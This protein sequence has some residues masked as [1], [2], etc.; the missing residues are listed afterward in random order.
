MVEILLRLLL[1]TETAATASI[2]TAALGQQSLLPWEKECGIFHRSTSTTAVRQQ[3][4]LHFDI[5][6]SNCC[7]RNSTASQQQST[8]R[9]DICGILLSSCA[10]HDNSKQ[11]VEQR[12]L[13]VVTGHGK[14]RS[15]IDAK[16]PSAI[17]RVC[18]EGL[19]S[20]GGAIPYEDIAENDGAFLIPASLAR[21]VSDSAKEWWKFVEH[22]QAWEQA[23]WHQHRYF[24]DP[25]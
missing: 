23:R 19:I 11:I 17:R 24:G 6:D 22:E 21:V 10:K 20:G 4:W 18:H 15:D 16:L 5:A 14:Q 1:V 3:L 13:L 12:G 2:A 8:G 7:Q 9:S 25:R